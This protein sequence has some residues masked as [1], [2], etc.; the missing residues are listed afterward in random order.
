MIRF[1]PAVTLPPD[2]CAG[3]PAGW[4]L[5]PEASKAMIATTLLAIATNNRTVTVYTSGFDANGFCAVNQVDPP[6]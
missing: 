6:N 5:I 2:N 1:N 3:A 4:M